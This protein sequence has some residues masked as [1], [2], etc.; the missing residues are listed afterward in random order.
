[1]LNLASAGHPGGGYLN[2]A[3]AQEENLFRRTTLS[4]SLE[5]VKEFKRTQKLYPIYGNEGIFSKNVVV[6]RGAESVSSNKAIRFFHQLSL[7]CS[8]TTTIMQ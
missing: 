7:H 5:F 3:G 6:F 4:Q 2:G 1:M 8:I